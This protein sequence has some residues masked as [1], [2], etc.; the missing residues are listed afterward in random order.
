MRRLNTKLFI[1]SWCEAP[2]YTGD[3]VTGGSAG[4]GGG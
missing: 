3:L 1:F 4:A 2:S